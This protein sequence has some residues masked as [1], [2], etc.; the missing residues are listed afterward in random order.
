[1][2]IASNSETGATPAT[3]GRIG[4]FDPEGRTTEGFDKIDHA[5]TDEIKADGVD[6]QAYTVS[7]ADQVITFR[8]PSKV[9][10][11]LEARTATPLD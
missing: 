7:L 5:A 10:L 3:G 8:R 6:H 4:V 9:K 2:R 1:M 11:V